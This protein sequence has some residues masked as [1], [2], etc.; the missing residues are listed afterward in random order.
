VAVVASVGIRLSTGDAQKKLKAL[1]SQSKKTQRVLEGFGDSAKSTAAGFGGMGATAQAATPGI[2]ALGVALK[3]ALGPI[4]AITTAAGAFSQ[5]FSVL[6]KQD[7]A[8]AKVRSLGVSS[9]ALVGKLKGVSAELQGQADIVELTASAYDVASAGFADAASASEVLSAA[10]KGAVGGFSDINIVADA[11]TSVLNAYGLEAAKA[12]QLVDGFIQTQND[13]KIVIGEYAANIAKVAPVAAALKVPLEEVNAAVAQITAGGQGAE[14]TFTALKTAFAQIAAGK[15]GKEF[16]AFGVEITASTLATDG[17]AKTLEKIKKSGADAGTVIKA[18]GTEAGPSILALLNDTEKYNKLLENQKNAQGAAAKAAFTAT[19]TIQG[20]VKR[21]QSAFTNLI[22]EQG[23][24]GD[25]I[26]NVFKIAAVTVEAFATAVNLVLVPFKAIDA[27]AAEIRNT[28]LGAIGTDAVGAAM[29]LE[30]AFQSV[31]AGIDKVGQFVIGLA[32]IIGRAIGGAVQFVLQSTEGLR[33]NLLSAFQNTIGQI[34]NLLQNFYD[35]IPAPIRALL[36]RV[37]GFAKGAF[38]AIMEAGAPSTAAASR[39][40]GGGGLDATGGAVSGG[41]RTSK[42]KKA[43]KDITP[44]LEAQVAL[45]SRLLQLNQQIA[46]AQIDGNKTAEQALKTEKILEQLAYEKNKINASEA[47]TDDKILQKRLATIAADER[48]NA[49][50]N[51]KFKAKADEAKKAEEVLLSLQNEQSK[52]E[53]ILAGKGEEYIL[54]EKINRILA[55]N[56]MLMEAQVRGIVEKNA[57]LEKSISLADKLDE[58]YKSVGSAI[59][60][61]IVDALTA[62]VDGTKDLADVASDVLKNIG[63]ILLQFGV[64]TTLSA[65]SQGNPFLSKL[66]GFAEGG[67]VTRP[68]NAIIG[69]GSEPEYIIPESKMKESMMR[70]SR[71]A[72]GNSVIPESGEGGASSE[73]SG[74]AISAPIDVRYS[75]E[76]I[77]NVDYVTADQFQA[78]MK[79]AAQQGAKQGEQQTLRRLQMSS[80]TRRRLGV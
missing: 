29:S 25:L 56:P 34:P 19:D 36:E 35:S 62:A 59:T 44:D 40:S 6:S 75:V 33:K 67:Y 26:K 52:L 2:G 43:E 55:E 39:S 22:S 65:V 76:R 69:E 1:A 73:G 37:I 78:G 3:G 8:E 14:V 54:N 30:N 27:A 20:Q 38:N 16:A 13:G 48:I 12:S 4:A 74:T 28:I 50:S 15:V 57:Q 9:D 11:T 64:Q 41:A 47:D 21:L 31:R 60:T 32:R 58:V 72:R 49:L 24:F 70:Y 10:G 53:A 7:F 23:V 42:A 77:N 80:S 66:F 46:N 63:N 5:I 68:T 79:Q 18:F 71:G 45:K 17:L 61:G 51:E